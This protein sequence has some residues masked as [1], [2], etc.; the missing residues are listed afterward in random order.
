MVKYI[1]NKKTRN[2]TP[3]KKRLNLKSGRWQ[4]RPFLWPLYLVMVSVRVGPRPKDDSSAK[5]FMGVGK[6]EIC[7][8]I[9][10]ED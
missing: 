8:L 6:P 5:I 9:F 10:V 2:K 1:S 7:Q 4:H 3:Q